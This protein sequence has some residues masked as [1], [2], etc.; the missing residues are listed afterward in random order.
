MKD[1]LEYL[2]E[3]G[4]VSEVTK[5]MGKMKSAWKITDEGRAYL[6]EGE[7]FE[8]R[9]AGVRRQNSEGGGRDGGLI[10]LGPG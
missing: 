4:F 2:T 6:D 10:Q 1:I 9:I 3:K 7:M 8:E 5:A